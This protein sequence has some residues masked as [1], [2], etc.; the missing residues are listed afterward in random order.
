MRT[1]GIISGGCKPPVAPSACPPAGGQALG[2]RDIPSTRVLA[3]TGRGIA[4]ANSAPKNGIFLRGICSSRRTRRRCGIK[5]GNLRVPR[6]PSGG[7]TRSCSVQELSAAAERVQTGEGLC[8]SP[9]PYPSQETCGFPDTLRA[10][11][12][13]L[14]GCSFAERPQTECRLG[15]GPAGPFPLPL[16][17]GATPQSRCGVTAPLMQGSRGGNPSVSLRADSSPYTG[18][19]RG[20]PFSP[21]RQGGKDKFY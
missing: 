18:E 7:L 10:G 2:A 21:L 13:G 8:P 6:H 17:P 20:Q 1:G 19:P 14:S 11:L 5:S 12:P 4:E 3:D 9:C 15:K 16:T